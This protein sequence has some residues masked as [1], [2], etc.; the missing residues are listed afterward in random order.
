MCVCVSLALLGLGGRE[1]G[2]NLPPLLRDGP[3]ALKTKANHFCVSALWRTPRPRARGDPSF[4]AFIRQI[5]FAAARKGGN[6][7]R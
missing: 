2:E 5:D 6:P 3:L 4:V 1:T 7:P